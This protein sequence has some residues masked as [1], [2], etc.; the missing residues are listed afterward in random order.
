MFQSAGV[1]SVPSSAGFITLFG[2]AASNG[3]IPVAHIK[4]IA[5]EQGSAKF[6]EAIVRGAS[7][8]L[9]PILTTETSTALALVSVAMG[10]GWA[11]SAPHAPLA[12]VVVCGLT[13]AT[14]LNMIVV[15]AAYQRIG[16]FPGPETEELGLQPQ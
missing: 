2:I 7:E 4:R 9:P 14:V 3:I 12:L 1:L 16:R 8:R 11:G 15:P 13:T 10:P 6:R 5:P